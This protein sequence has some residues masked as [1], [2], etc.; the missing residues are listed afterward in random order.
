MAKQQGD[1][2]I[3]GDWVT[4]TNSKNSQN[5]ADGM[6]KFVGRTVQ[7]TEAGNGVIRFDGYEGFGWVYS[8]GH[9]EHA[10]DLAI[11]ESITANWN[12]TTT[13]YISS[14]TTYQGFTGNYGSPVYFDSK[15]RSVKLKKEEEIVKKKLII[16]ELN[17]DNV[18]VF[19][20]PPIYLNGLYGFYD[21]EKDNFVFP[22][23][24]T[25]DDYEIQ[26]LKIIPRSSITTGTDISKFLCFSSISMFCKFRIKDYKLSSRLFSFASKKAQLVGKIVDVH[27]IELGVKC[28]KSEELVNT[29]YVNTK[30]FG[31]LMF[32]LDDID[33]IY[34]NIKG[35]NIKKNKSLFT[36]NK[37]GEIRN[38]Q[39]KEGDELKIANPKGIKY[40]EHRDVI[41]IKKI[42]TI[43][44]NI[45]IGFKGK[46]NKTK[47]LEFIS[48]KQF[49]RVNYENISEQA[50]KESTII[51]EDYF[52]GDFDEEDFEREFHEREEQAF[53]EHL[54]RV[55]E[56]AIR[57]R[58]VIES[59][60]KGS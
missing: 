32:V 19:K 1:P 17:K 21:K 13:N 43:G 28:D 37:L 60:F 49:K 36:S 54:Q 4:I 56:E 26:K 22:G 12:N 45:Y 47:E 27:S 44:N 42:K 18:N 3:A 52:D 23:L 6:T 2:F 50:I 25:E 7:I 8:N 24:K 11:L 33:I 10:T 59:S 53:Q 51:E 58:Q 15:T 29:L 35:Y 40:A 55:R 41:I 30:E 34:P 31:N 39:V 57:N 9:F 5:W 48:I 14:V 46:N 20:Y 16:T 38:V